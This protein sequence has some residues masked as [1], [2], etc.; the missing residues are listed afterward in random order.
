MSDALN[1]KLK[2]EVHE[3]A[4]KRYKEVLDQREEIMT[5]FVAKYKCEP[6]DMVQVEWRKSVSE[7]LWF[8]V[9][10]SDCIFC[11]KCNEKISDGN[12]V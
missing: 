1:E 5:A 4:R 8:L 12:P 3:M 6:D 7:M 2:L 9:R 11:Q 10:K